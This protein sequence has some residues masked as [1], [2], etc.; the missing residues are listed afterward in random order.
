MLAKLDF[1]ARDNLIEFYFKKQK[2]QLLGNLGHTA[3]V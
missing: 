2:K 1:G 3:A